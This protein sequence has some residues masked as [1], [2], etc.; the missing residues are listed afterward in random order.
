MLLN[1]NWLAHPKEIGNARTAVSDKVLAILCRHY[2]REKQHVMRFTHHAEHIR[3]PEIRRILLKIAARE[4]EHANWL[5]VKITA[6]GG[7]P[8]EVMSIRYSSENVWSY[9]RSDL[10]E[11]HRCLEEVA[12]DRA[13]LGDGFPDIAA[14]LER[15]EVDAKKHRKELRALFEND[16]MTPWAA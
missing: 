5:A 3:E 11:E 1:I 15:I 7:R 2:V 8:P 10:D 14:I 13:T 12:E 4:A 6:L 9:L 16:A